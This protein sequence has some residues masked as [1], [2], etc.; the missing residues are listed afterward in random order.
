MIKEEYYICP[1]CD[2]TAKVERYRRYHAVNKCGPPCSC[3]NRVPIWHYVSVPVPSK[4]LPEHPRYVVTVDGRIGRNGRELKFVMVK[5]RHK[6]YA[7]PKY[8]GDG[9]TSVN[10]ARAVGRAFCPDYVEGYSAEFL[11]GDP[12]NC[13]ATNLRW[14]PRVGP[15]KKFS[16]KLAI[17]QENG[18]TNP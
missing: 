4:P 9:Y 11:D 15:F 14:H 17:L 3:K 10:C 2:Q 18:K 1:G 8:R 6:K 7:F 12:T 5:G 13:A 16:K